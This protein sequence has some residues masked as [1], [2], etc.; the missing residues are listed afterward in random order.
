LSPDGIKQLCPGDVILG[1]YARLSHPA[2]TAEPPTTL[3]A[4]AGMALGLAAVTLMSYQALPD[5]LPAIAYPLRLAIW[6]VNG[7]VEPELHLVPN[8][9]VAAVVLN[10]LGFVVEPKTEQEQVCA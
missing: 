9:S 6:R 2:V 1:G 5:R 10:R 7:A 8:E 3:K 4:C